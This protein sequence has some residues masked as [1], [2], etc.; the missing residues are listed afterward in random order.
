[1]KVQRWQTMAKWTLFDNTQFF[2]NLLKILVPQIDIACLSLCISNFGILA[3]ESVRNSAIQATGWVRAQYQLNR[4]R[5]S[6]FGTCNMQQFYWNHTYTTIR[7]TLPPFL[8]KSRIRIPLGFWAEPRPRWSQA[9]A[10]PSRSAGCQVIEDQKHEPNVAMWARNS[11]TLTHIYICLY[12]IS[13][14]YYILY[15]YIHTFGILKISEIIS[16]LE[17]E[18]ILLKKCWGAKSMGSCDQIAWNSQRESAPAG[19]PG[20][21]QLRQLGCDAFVEIGPQ[22]ILVKRLGWPIWDW[23]Q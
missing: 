18:H 16:C 15:T 9:H 10:L 21:A 23:P 6:N 5:V 1:M 14:L 2:G 7:D 8:W 19:A 17:G 22:P 12:Y 20:M 3:A 11:Q 13:E 4:L